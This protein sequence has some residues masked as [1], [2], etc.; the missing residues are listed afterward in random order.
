MSEIVKNLELNRST[1]CIYLDLSK[2]FNT[3]QH[4]VIIKKLELY[5]IW[6]QCLNWVESYLNN[7]SLRV[8]CKTDHDTITRSSEYPLQY[9]A[10]QGSC[11]G[12]LLFLIFCNDL[13]LNLL[14]LK[15]IQFA[16]DTTLYI[17]HYK[18]SYINYCIEEDLQ[19]IQNWFQANKLTLNADKTVAMYFSKKRQPSPK[20]PIRLE[21]NRQKIP[22]VDHTKFLGL[23][24]DNQLNWKTHISKIETT[25]KTKLCMLQRGKNL[26][27]THAKKILYFAQIQ[28]HLQYGLSIWG[29]MSPRYQLRRLQKLQNRGVQITM[30]REH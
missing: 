16:D 2:A 23:W 1:V 4:D 30:N 6:G 10:P 21:L 26:L 20:K 22:L 19:R 13:E 18:I 28:S 15:T 24:I 3:L 9:G 14:H 25:L 7:R 12:P 11:L 8:K 17:S 27:T 29:N 5:G